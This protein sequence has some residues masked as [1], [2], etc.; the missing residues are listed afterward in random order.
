[1]EDRRYYQALTR[2]MAM[3]MILVSFAPLLLISGIIGHRFETSYREKVLAHLVEL[4][5]KH[6]QTINI[7]L[8][9][10]LAIHEKTYPDQINAS[11]QFSQALQQLTGVKY[12]KNEC[13]LGFFESYFEWQERK[14]KDQPNDQS[15]N[16]PEN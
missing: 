4:V 12:N 2:K 5:Q 1:M 7:F 10:K 6:Q 8:N 16:Q 11:R 14:R 3:I 15:D 13:A 9:E